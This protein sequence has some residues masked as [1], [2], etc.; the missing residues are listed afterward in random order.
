MQCK[1]RS[2]SLAADHKH[3]CALAQVDEMCGGE[4]AG[5]PGEW[6]LEGSGAESRF[7]VDLQGPHREWSPLNTL[8]VG[9]LRDVSQVM[10]AAGGCLWTPTFNGSAAIMRLAGLT[11]HPATHAV[12]LL[13]RHLV[14]RLRRVVQRPPAGA[15]NFR[16]GCPPDEGRLSFSQ[17]RHAL[18]LHALGCLTW[19]PRRVSPDDGEYK[20]DEDVAEDGV[21]LD[22]D[23]DRCCDD[24]EEGH[25]TTEQWRRFGFEEGAVRAEAPLHLWPIYQRVYAFCAARHERLGANS[26]C[27]D[28]P[29]VVFRHVL[30]YVLPY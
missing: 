17:R 27:R 26:R 13:P 11:R 6:W 2:E 29:E 14:G 12:N 22:T 25:D 16:G 5:P 10:G 19:D 15:E 8:L 28:L 24:G 4:Q 7:C 3:C 9:V 18:R 23:F 21:T 1:I 20:S 30:E